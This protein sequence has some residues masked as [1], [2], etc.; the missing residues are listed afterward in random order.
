MNR[1]PLNPKRFFL[2]ILFSTLLGISFSV[3]V[4][5]YDEDNDDFGFGNYVEK[6][7]MS[8][9]L[10]RQVRTYYPPFVIGRGQAVRYLVQSVNYRL[11][12]EYPAPEES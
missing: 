12:T 1:N 6:E 8:N 3:S 4:L 10:R 9:P 2:S 7:K 11:V 5:A